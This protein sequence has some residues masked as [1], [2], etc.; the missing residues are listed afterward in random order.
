MSAEI[1]CHAGNSAALQKGFSGIAL[2][3][4]SFVPCF[5]LGFIYATH[6]ID[7]YALSSEIQCFSAVSQTAALSFG[8]WSVYLMYDLHRTH[9]SLRRLLG[10]GGAVGGILGILS[11]ASI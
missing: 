9:R 5:A 3:L 1:L 4:L 10:W 8:L 2:A 11:F 6:T 7:A